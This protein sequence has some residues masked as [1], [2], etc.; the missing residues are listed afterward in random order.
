[1]FRKWV[2]R[3]A[4]R[5]SLKVLPAAIPAT[6][7]DAAMLWGIRSFVKLLSGEP[8]LSVQE[9]LLCMVLIAGLR[10]LFLRFRA[11][12]SEKTFRNFSA[13]M[14]G[15]FL[16]TLRSLHPKFFH[17]KTAD[18]ELRSAFEAAEALPRSGRSLVQTLQAA[19]QL[20]VFVPVLFFISWQL[21]LFL[22]F[23]MTPLLSYVQKRVRKMAGE[24]RLALEGE[25]ELRSDF[26]TLKHTFREWSSPEEQALGISAAFQK[27]REVNSNKQRLVSRQ[28]SLSLAVETIS[29][30]AMVF[31]LAI[32]AWMISRS[33]MTPEA[34]V[35]YASAVFL[36]YKPL[37]ECARAIPEIRGAATSLA[38]L[39]ALAEFP[40]RAR[41]RAFGKELAVTDAEFSYGA[42][43][44]F[45]GFSC[46]HEFKPGEA[47]FLRG[48]N[49]AGKSTLLRLFAGLEQLDSGRVTLPASCGGT[50][51]VSQ[52]VFLPPRDFL[53]QK[54]A[55]AFQKGGE[56]PAALRRFAEISGA[57][58]LAGKAGLSGGERA[59]L[60]LFWA[61]LSKEPLLL[62]D[63][64]FAYIAL[65]SREKIMRE[66]L[67]AAFELKKFVVVSGHEPFPENL[68]N[69]FKF[70]EIPRLGA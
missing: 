65:E 4:V 62:L 35:L 17:S 45:K 19:V 68:Q 41:Q 40:K 47:L 46:G 49:G 50:F 24:A 64:P 59:R 8:L 70:L 33:W 3:F 16:K 39:E 63:E 10:F 43:P 6:L 67:R 69:S 2:K 23:C 54:I 13:A 29:V 18:A 44:V 66:F 12:L 60:A 37:K 22:F 26:E 11:D 1:M 21:T 14:E 53:S 34:L 5:A 7:A 30:L 15:R 42:S 27:I 25:G 31:V 58:N 57:R 48:E 51:F 36:C 52:G 20:V 28:I 56:G 38:V 55:A 32:C 61:L 9:W